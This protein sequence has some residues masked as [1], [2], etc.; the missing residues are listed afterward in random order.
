M[1]GGSKP[2][3]ATPEVVGKIETYVEEREPHHL[4]LGDQGQTHRREYLQRQHCAACI[5]NQQNTDVR[6]R[7]NKLNLTSLKG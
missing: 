2:K 1:I 7:L 5:L 6:F 3:V 4:C